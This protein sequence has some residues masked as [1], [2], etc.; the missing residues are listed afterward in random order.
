MKD[1]A[2]SFPGS[3]YILLMK[4][5]LRGKKLRKLRDEVLRYLLKCWR[6]NLAFTGEKII[7]LNK[8]WLK[9]LFISLSKAKKWTYLLVNKRPSLFFSKIQLKIQFQLRINLREMPAKNLQILKIS[10][11]V[12]P[13]KTFQK[14]VKLSS[15]KSFLPNLERKVKYF[16]YG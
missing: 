2:T 5:V 8:N 16:L 4:E 13:Y 6:K 9:F 14:F 1:W 12:N 10:K 7:S 15:N 3:F 11:L